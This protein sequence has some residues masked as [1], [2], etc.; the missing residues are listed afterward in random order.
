MNDLAQ[1]ETDIAHVAPMLLPPEARV[2]TLE[3]VQAQ[4]TVRVYLDG[5]G[6]LARWADLDATLTPFV[7]RR[8]PP[9]RA[10]TVVVQAVRQDRPGPVEVFGA[11]VWVEE[12]TATVRRDVGASDSGRA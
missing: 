9:G 1:L 3:V 10:W 6:S 8:L 7:E 5:P 4:L 2:L 12:G 11:P